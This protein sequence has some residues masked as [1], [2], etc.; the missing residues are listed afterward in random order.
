[1][2]DRIGGAQRWSL[3]LL[4]MAGTLNLFDRT[5]VNVLGEQIKTELVI[6]DA[7][8][9]LLTGTAFGLLYSVAIVPIARL[10]DRTNRVWVIASALTAWSACTALCG[11]AGNFIQLFLARMGVGMA[12][13]GG[14]PASVS[15]VRDLFPEGRRASATAI[16]LVGA[17]AGA[18]LG[19]LLGGFMGTTWGWRIALFAAAVPGLVVAAMMFLTM[20]DPVGDPG[21]KTETGTLLE[22]VKILGR[23]RS[24]LWLTV[25]FACQ[26]FCLFATAAW[27]PP[28][29]IR[30][31][32]MTALEVGRFLGLAVGL[33]GAVGALGVGFLCD[34]FRRR[35][36]PRDWLLIK[37]V[38]VANLPL[39]A[40][41]VLTPSLSVALACVIALS[42]TVYGYLG[43]IPVLIQQQATS[44][45]RSLSLGG[46]TAV[47]NIMSMCIGVPTVGLLSDTLHPYFGAPAVGY[48]LAIMI[49]AAALIGLVALGQAQ[50]SAVDPAAT[51]DDPKVAEALP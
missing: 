36:R 32:D 33:G 40:L 1:M 34:H 45:T 23:R 8:L 50:K 49:G 28:F 31:H 11:L 22:A 47:A 51:A 5:I 44:G 13:A 42:M 10:A 21:R 27:L 30:A 35:G 19:L 29:F 6:S 48:A 2:T 14:Q 16:L 4:F 39:I 7:Q 41:T 37:I 26:T 9:G 43:P 12:E 46:V 38:M 15:L 3:A 18:C 24:L 17:P 25:A 20:R